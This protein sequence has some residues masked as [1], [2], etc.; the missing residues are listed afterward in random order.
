MS[1]KTKLGLV[2]CALD[3]ARE[4]SRSEWHATLRRERERRFRL[5]LPL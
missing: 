3:H 5:L 4:A 1:L 2:A